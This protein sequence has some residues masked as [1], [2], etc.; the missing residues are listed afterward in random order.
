VKTKATWS[1]VVVYEDAQT[2]ELAVAFCDRM[3]QRHWANL[4]FDVSWWSF[5]SLAE[6]DSANNAATKTVAADLLLVATRPEKEL[7]FHIRAWAESWIP[8]RSERD[9]NLVG[10]PTPDVEDGPE[11]AATRAYLRTLALRSGMDYLTEFPEDLS[12]PIPESLEVYAERANQVTS[13]LDEIL[14]P[15]TPLP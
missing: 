5:D 2:R 8:Q 6:A 3:V 14:N 9:G 11:T 7:P 4:N 13:V 15:S 1:V 10:L 12:H